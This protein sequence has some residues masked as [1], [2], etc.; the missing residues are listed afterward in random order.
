M[1]TFS[2]SKVGIII[3]SY[4]DRDFLKTC[5]D[6]IYRWTPRELFE[7]IISSDVTDAVTDEYIRKLESDGWCK[8]LFAEERSW[9]TGT[10]NQGI[11]YALE[12]EPPFSHVLLLNSDVAVLPGWLSHMLG[13]MY[14]LDC[15]IMGCKTLTGD[16]M[17]D[18][19]GGAY[20]VGHHYGIRRPNNGYFEPRVCK[21]GD[22]V[23]GA[24][25]LIRRD[26]IE[27]IG[28]LDEVNFPHIASDREYCLAASRAGWKIGFSPATIY[29]F[30]L[31]HHAEKEGHDGTRGR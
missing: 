20:G 11:K 8:G 4:K 30:T 24:C 9:Y 6:S 23:T 15:G 12:Q 26:V 1:P 16:G 7:L 19:L 17:G 3:A 21:P 25:F 29:H 14:E 27:K 10:N 5:L 13:D 22:W 28:L 18:H 2:N 31:I